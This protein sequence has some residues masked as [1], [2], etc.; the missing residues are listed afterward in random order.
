MLEVYHPFC[1]EIWRFD[2]NPE[3]SGKNPETGKN[4]ENIIII[5]Y[6]ISKLSIMWR[7]MVKTI[8]IW[9][10]EKN[11]KKKPHKKK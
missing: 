7:N 5:S 9:R 6:M 4:P 1:E 2:A 8:E 11:H 10:F 3:K